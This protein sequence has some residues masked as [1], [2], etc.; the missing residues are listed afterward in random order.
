MDQEVVRR[1]GKSTIVSLLD[2]SV[3]TD[4]H[5]QIFQLEVGQ[6]TSVVGKSVSGTVYEPQ[7]LVVEG[8]VL[9]AIYE[10]I[11][12]HVGDV[13]RRIEEMSG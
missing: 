3:E 12:Q 5:R 8:K 1:V 6:V 9:L 2:I 11:G 7:R 13:Q 10:L 4:P